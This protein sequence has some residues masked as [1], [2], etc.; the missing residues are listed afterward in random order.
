M[1]ELMLTFRII[2]EWLKAMKRHENEK[3]HLLER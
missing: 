3:V 1:G 2:K